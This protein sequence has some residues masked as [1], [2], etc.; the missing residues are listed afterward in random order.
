[1]KYPNDKA[2]KINR[3]STK[4]RFLYFP[5]ESDFIFMST[6]S[7]KYILKHRK[8]YVSFFLEILETPS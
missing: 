1:M 5:R 4:A 7:L 6:I 2:Q 8:L 3:C